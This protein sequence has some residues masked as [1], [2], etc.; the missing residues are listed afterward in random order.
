M[1]NAKSQIKLKYQYIGVLPKSVRI[2][3]NGFWGINDFEGNE[4]LSSNYLEIFTLS[5]GVGL[6][7]AREDSYWRIFNMLGEQIN[8]DKY[9]S[10]YPYYG[11]FGFTK[12]KIGKNFGIINKYG[13]KIIPP[14][15]EKIEIFGKGFV[16]HKFD[17][18]KEFFTNDELLGLPTIKSET[19]LN[20]LKEPVKQNLKTIIS[21]KS[22]SF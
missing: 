12:I 13:K 5:S 18:T 1:N 14:I 21:T 22:K 20:Y 2:K 3:E 15:Y 9:D 4:I 8:N 7:A 10:L 6:I 11:K 17:L 16:F 19:N